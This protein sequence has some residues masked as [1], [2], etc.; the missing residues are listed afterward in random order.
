M[1]ENI[2]LSDKNN[3]LTDGIII[4][5]CTISIYL[6]AFA[7]EYGFSSYFKIPVS[8]IEINITSLLFITTL[9]SYYLF[10]VF[11]IFLSVIVIFWSGINIAIVK[12]III[13]LP[14]YFVLFFNIYFFKANWK[15]WLSTL[16]IIF[17]LSLIYSLI[18]FKFSI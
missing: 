10:L 16:C 14:F 7:Y 1:E 9:A 8:F 11:L 15:Y 2:K 17:G 4:F 18:T 12:S 6:I 5:T 13:L 3:W